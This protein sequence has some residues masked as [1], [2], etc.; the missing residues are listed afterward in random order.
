MFNSKIMNVFR[1]QVAIDHYL[2]VVVVVVKI[3]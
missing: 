3:L 2:V 1:E